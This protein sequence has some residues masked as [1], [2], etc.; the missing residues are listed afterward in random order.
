MQK[1][2]K[3]KTP[4]Y[5][6]T[7][8]LV[9]VLLFVAGQIFAA[10]VFIDSKS[11]EVKIGAQFEASIF[12]DTEEAYINAIE[13]KIIFPADL[14]ELKEIRD[15][16]S[17]VNFW[18]ERARVESAGQ[19]IFSGITPG[20]YIGERG[21]IF[22][23]IFKSKKEGRGIIEI[24][25][26][27]TLLNDGKGTEAMVTTSDLQF[28]ISGQMSPSEI[29]IPEIVDSDSP[30]P[31][32]LIIAQDSEIFDGKYFLVFTAQDKGAGI[33]HYEILEAS[34]RGSLQGLIKKEEWQGG[35]SPYVLRDQKLKSYI[36][37]KAIDRAGNERIATLHPQNSLKWYENYFVY[38][39]IIVGFVVIYM[40]WWILRKRK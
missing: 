36:Y 35:E 20:G 19:V 31:F 1:P 12:L 25:S 27:K 9:S 6:L 34:Q 11:Q 21:L 14:L 15:G 29:S 13:G 40:L 24:H 2:I 7:I 32:E 37:V 38:I 28:L 17:I 18:I 23:I 39:I 5:F 26:A 33:D 3:L 4:N 22:S 30:E 8:L 10:R 16:N